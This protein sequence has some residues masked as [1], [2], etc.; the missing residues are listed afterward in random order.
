MAKKR[1]LILDQRR[2]ALEA[3]LKDDVS[4]EMKWVSKELTRD[5]GGKKSIS[6][7]RDSTCKGS[8]MEGSMEPSGD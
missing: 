4:G 6:S 7:Q 5:R 3:S 8:V 1:T 2:G